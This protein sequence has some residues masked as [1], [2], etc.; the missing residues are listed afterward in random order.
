[1]KKA[2]FDVMELRE[3]ETIKKGDALVAST[4]RALK[5]DTS[6]N[7]SKQKKFRYLREGPE[8]E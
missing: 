8:K 2:A 3:K 5:R 7:R 1:M 6:L 4:W